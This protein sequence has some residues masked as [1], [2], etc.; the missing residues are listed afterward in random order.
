[1]AGPRHPTPDPYPP[2]PHPRAAT[3]PH[4][5]SRADLPSSYVARGTRTSLDLPAPP[6]NHAMA[7]TTANSRKRRCVSTPIGS[8]VARAVWLMIFLLSGNRPSDAAHALMLLASNGPHSTSSGHRHHSLFRRKSGRRSLPPL[9]EAAADSPRVISLPDDAT[10]Q[11]IH[12]RLMGFALEEARRA[13]QMGEVPIGAIVVREIQPASV[14]SSR[15]SQNTTN[16]REFELLSTGRNLVETNRDASAHAELE[17][18]KLAASRIGNWRL[19]NTTLYS[20]LE[21]CPMCLSAAQAFRC[22]SVVYGAPDM[23]L[24]AV[25]THIKL[26]DEKHPY[27]D[28][29]AIGGILEEESADLLK[30]FFRRR[31]TQRRK[32]ASDFDNAA[33]GT[34]AENGRVSINIT[35]RGR[36]IHIVKKIFF[37]KR[38]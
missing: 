7:T 8:D 18:L 12:A 3:L 30:N 36:V 15:Q 32:K 29:E 21:P 23:R 10:E 35:R 25:E 33:T 17:A 6:P 5:R 26:L 38:R 34:T 1:M 9:V 2:P 11:E 37:W 24:G 27:H 16:A 20:T 31:R 14:L 22:K 4:Y 19:L 28:V 13:G